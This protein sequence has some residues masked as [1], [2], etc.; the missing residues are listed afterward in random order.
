MCSFLLTDLIMSQIKDKPNGYIHELLEFNDAKVS[1][2]IFTLSLTVY[3]F[4]YITMNN[5]FLQREVTAGQRA[6]TYMVY[7]EFNNFDS[8]S[9]LIYFLNI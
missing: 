4:N 6:I 9:Y 2:T 5:H 3:I 8:L 7:S 1:P